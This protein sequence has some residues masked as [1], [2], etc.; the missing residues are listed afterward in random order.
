MPVSVLAVAVGIIDDRKEQEIVEPF[1][2]I[3]VGDLLRA[4]IAAESL[5][6]ARI[7]STSWNPDLVSVRADRGL[8]VRTELASS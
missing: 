4:R 8:Q 5:R 7:P 1:R 3:I 2:Q 6:V